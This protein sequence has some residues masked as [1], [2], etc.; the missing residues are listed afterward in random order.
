MLHFSLLPGKYA[1]FT[2]KRVR[3]EVGLGTYIVRPTP[4][5]KNEVNM[6]IETK[7]LVSLSRRVEKYLI[8]A[9]IVN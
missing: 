2:F 5:S 8:H 1:Y 9:H 3:M 6:G 4:S 7:T